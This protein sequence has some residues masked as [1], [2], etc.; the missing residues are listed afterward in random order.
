MQTFGL[1][2]MEYPQHYE[3]ICKI[4]DSLVS[5]TLST[6]LVSSSLLSGHDVQFQSSS[7]QGLNN[8]GDGK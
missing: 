8:L 5:S 2:G 6:T 7:E 4:M 1:L 3:F